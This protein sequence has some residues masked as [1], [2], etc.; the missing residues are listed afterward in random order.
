MKVFQSEYWSAEA[1]SPMLSSS[2][3]QFVGISLVSSTLHVG[4]CNVSATILPE[5]FLNSL[6]LFT[7]F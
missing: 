4:V 3:A 7:F 1:F 6:N 5:I 2:S